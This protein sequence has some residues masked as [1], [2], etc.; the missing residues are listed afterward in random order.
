MK[1]LIIYPTFLCPFACQYCMFKNKLS[2]NEI[3]SLNVLKDYLQKNND[4]DSF[5]ISGGDPLI[6][7][8]SYLNELITILKSYNKPITLNAYPHQRNIPSDVYYDFSYDFLSKPRAA[9]VWENLLSFEFPFKITITLSPIMFKYHP[10][11][12]LQKLSLLPKLKEV[13]F[14]PYFKNECN[15]YDITKNDSF[16]KMMK[17]IYDTKLN[18]P[19]KITNKEILQKKYL[20]SFEPT[21]ELNLFPNGK[22]YNKVFENDILLFQESNIYKSLEYPDSINMYSEDLIEWFKNNLPN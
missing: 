16:K 17:M 4:M 2:L 3:L 10:N 18:L 19:F 22:T 21:L 20:K 12:L 1:N 9:E 13:E 5:V 14:I 6:L 15:Q 11:N 8:Q 7:P